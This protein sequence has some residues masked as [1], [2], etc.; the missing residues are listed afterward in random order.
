MRPSPLGKRKCE[1]C[2][3]LHSNLCFLLFNFCRTSFVH[4]CI[5]YNAYSLVN[6]L[7]FLYMVFLVLITDS[8]FR[9]NCRAQQF[10]KS[11][12]VLLIVEYG[13]NKNMHYLHETFRSLY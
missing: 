10:S 4:V 6:S 5:Y 1:F 13:K 2:M 7:C 11:L 9:I 12:Q 8:L 3:Y